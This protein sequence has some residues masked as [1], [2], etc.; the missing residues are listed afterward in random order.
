ML[1]TQFFSARFKKDVVIDMICY[2][3]H[4]HNEGDEPMFTQPTM[5][6]KIAEHPTTCEIYANKLVAEGVL[7]QED[8]EQ[9]KADIKKELDE[10]FEAAASYK[11]NKA[12]WLDGAW[13][14]LSVAS[15]DARRGDTGVSME[16]LEAL[17]P[18]PTP[19]K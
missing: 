2:R 3:R 1:H 14:R 15:G 13:E 18:A 4:G 6:K 5:Y 16:R 12:D 8:L 11:A 9:A 7:T 19:V 17:G 10:A